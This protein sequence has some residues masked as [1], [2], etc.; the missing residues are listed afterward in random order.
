MRSLQSPP[1]PRPSPQPTP[2]PPPSPPPTL[3]PA[4]PRPT[5]FVF[6]D[7]ADQYRLVMAALLK[8]GVPAI[9]LQPAASA[10]C[11]GGA[12]VSLATGPIEVYVEKV[13]G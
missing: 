7:V 10:R 12:L 9:A 2:D 5:V 8:A 11:R 1:P 3:P 4:H 6:S 13:F